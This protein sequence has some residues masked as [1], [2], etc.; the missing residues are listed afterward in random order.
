MQQRLDSNIVQIRN[1]KALL[2][3]RISTL[4][5]YF[6]ITEANIRSIAQHS[7]CVEQHIRIIWRCHTSLSHYVH[8]D[9]HVRYFGRLCATIDEKKNSIEF[10][11]DTDNDSD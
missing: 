4:N 10:G 7:A 3:R 1:L 2:D 5:L 9:G 11:Y 8:A 6:V